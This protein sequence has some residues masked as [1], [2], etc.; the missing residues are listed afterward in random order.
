[1]DVL[2]LLVCVDCLMAIANDDYTGMDLTRETAVRTGLQRWS[3]DGFS[4]ACGDD[5]H[6]FSS[7]RCD[8]CLTDLAGSRHQ[9]SALDWSREREV[10]HVPPATPA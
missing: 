4:L 1:M 5:T 7:H 2:E 3:N 10:G 6:A 8:V 9:V